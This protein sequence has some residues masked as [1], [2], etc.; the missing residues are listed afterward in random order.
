ML[1]ESIKKKKN[2][3]LQI[4]LIIYFVT[5]NK[6]SDKNEVYLQDLSQLSNANTPLPIP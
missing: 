5:G 4:K 3:V 2:S 1:K 6:Y